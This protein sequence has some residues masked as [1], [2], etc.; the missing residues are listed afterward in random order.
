[1]GET[2]AGRGGL[3]EPDWT[4]HCGDLWR[5]HVLDSTGNDIC[6]IVGPSPRSPADWAA[7]MRRLSARAMT[8]VVGAV[9]GAPI[10]HRMAK[11]GD[12]VRRGWALGI[13]RG[14]SAE[15][16]GGDM[17]PMSDVDEAWPVRGWT[18]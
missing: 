11:R 3:T 5:G 7:M 14:E 8:G 1:M 6:D 18:G 16:F 13:C 2:E 4:A 12:I 9:H 15:F 10:D 17:V